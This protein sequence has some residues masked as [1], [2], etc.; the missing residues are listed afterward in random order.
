[1]KHPEQLEPI[2]FLSSQNRM[3]NLIRI[4]LIAACMP[5]IA[6]ARAFQQADTLRTLRL[7]E[8]IR[9]TRSA[10]PDVAASRLAAEAMAT[11]REQVTALPD[12]MVMLNVQPFPVYTARG[13]QAAQLRV[14]QP[15]PFPGKLGLMGEMA[16]LSA[17][18]ATYATETLVD[19][20]TLQVKLAFFELYRL[21]QHERLIHEFMSTLQDYESV[22]VTQ[23]EVGRG[24]QQAILKAQLER[25][26]LSKQLLDLS[27]QRKSQ[28]QSLAK[29]VD[30][31]VAPDTSFSLDI[32][33]TEGLSL[34]EG[35]L[36]SV[37]IESRPELESLRT[38]RTRADASESLAKKSFY[39]DFGVNVTYFNITKADM[40]PSA[41]GRDALALGLS[42]KIP[43]QR[44]KLHSRLQETRLEQMRIDSN[45]ESFAAQLETRI[46]DLSNRV[47]DDA[48]QL[49]L[50]RD[51]LIPQAETT[52]EATLSAYTTGRTDFLNLLDAERVLFNVRMGYEDVVVRYRKS[53]A[54]LER[55]LGVTSLQEANHQ[56]DF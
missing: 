17:E 29:F 42:V 38:S 34:S 37:A 6:R 31:P 14:E 28:L 30:R 22:A 16:D 39:P 19:N 10:N 3:H 48:Q 43:L 9:E 52:L 49:T 56:S 32:G 45:I 20:L 2:V 5:G 23:Y 50:Y 44:G 25:N 11:R 47:R 4:L 46:G 12:P 24:M 1:L 7:D 13:T 33:Q 18:M 51:A 41:D 55:E 21:Q 8:L 40:P 15:I 53:Y 35:R 26:T 54:M 27:W 36:V